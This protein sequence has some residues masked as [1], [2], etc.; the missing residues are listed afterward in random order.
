MDQQNWYGRLYDGKFKESSYVPYVGMDDKAYRDYM[1]RKSVRERAI[2]DLA[3][4]IDEI[5]S[6]TSYYINESG[7]LQLVHMAASYQMLFYC[8]DTAV[9][10]VLNTELP[11][12]AF[13]EK[14]A[15]WQSILIDTGIQMA[16]LTQPL[17]QGQFRQVI[18]A[19]EGDLID[20]LKKLPYDNL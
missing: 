11:F 20:C 1:R 6:K 12:E 10:Y 15:I 19:M 4:E 5:G 17:Q 18:W 8:G 3:K 13:Q 16:I 9:Y 2:K 7:V 14:T